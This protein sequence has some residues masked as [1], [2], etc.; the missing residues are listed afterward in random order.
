[1]FKYSTKVRNARL[2]A[3][4]TVIGPAPLM[5]FFRAARIAPRGVFGPPTATGRNSPAAHLAQ[6]GQRLRH[7]SGRQLARAGARNRHHSQ[8][9]TVRQEGL[10]PFARFGVSAGSRRRPH[11]VEHFGRSGTTSH[12]RRFH[13]RQLERRDGA[14]Q[15]RS[16]A[17]CQNQQLDSPRRR[18]RPRTAC[19]LKLFQS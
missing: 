14:G 15:E 19:N 16:A 9:P 18:T 4:R 17:Q 5:K 1:M 2:D 11:I 6:S 3:I 13:H 7:N 10:L 12:C 8:L